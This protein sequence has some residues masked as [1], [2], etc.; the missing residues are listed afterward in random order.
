MT[1]FAIAHDPPT[2]K[3]IPNLQYPER[4]PAE[5]AAARFS[6]SGRHAIGKSSQS[7]KKAL[8]KTVFHVLELCIKL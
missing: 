6:L 3:P 2:P 4:T 8:R 7:R 1:P 5:R